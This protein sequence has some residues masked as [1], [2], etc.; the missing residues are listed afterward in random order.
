MRPSALN[1][2]RHPRTG[3]V[4]WRQQLVWGLAGMALPLL[5]GAWLQAQHGDWSTQLQQERRQQAQQQAERQ[6]QRALRDQEQLQGQRQAVWQTLQ[7]QQQRVLALQLA[8]QR[9][10]EQGVRLTRWQA[11]GQRL[12]LQ[13]QSLQPEHVPDLQARLGQTLGQRWALVE[14]TAGPADEGVSWSLETPWPP[15]SAP[16]GAP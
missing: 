5:L 16:R 15:A 6:R 2:L 3:A 8:L 1:L 9:E 4:A 7:A 12:R 10:A 14:L 13:G 11:D